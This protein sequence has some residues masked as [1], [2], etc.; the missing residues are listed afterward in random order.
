MDDRVTTAQVEALYPFQAVRI[1]WSQQVDVDDM[2]LAFERV[3]VML[4]SAPQPLHLVMDT[5][6]NL[7]IPLMPLIQSLLNGPLT[8]PRLGTCLIVGPSGQARILAKTLSEMA[9][10]ATV[11]WC[12]ND[13]VALSHLRDLT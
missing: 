13:E 1:Q 2:R 10:E 6:H 5:Q 12:A 7:S 8:H 4:D 9:R 3:M 11:R